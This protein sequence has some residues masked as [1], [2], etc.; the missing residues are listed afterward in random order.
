MMLV[1]VLVPMIVFATIFGVLFIFFTTRNRERLA[2]IEKG[3]DPSIFTTTLSR[4]GIKVG[5]LAVGISLGILLSQ[6][7][8]HV[9][10][11]DEELATISM[12]FLFAGAGLVLE[13]FLAKKEKQA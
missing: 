3:V 1:E 4:I 12:I 2:M 11:M 7:I 8:I 6:L 9:T 13:H 10:N 5:L